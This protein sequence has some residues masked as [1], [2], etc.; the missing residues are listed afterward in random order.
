MLDSFLTSVFL[1]LMHLPTINHINLSSIWN[2]PLSSLALSVNLHQLDIFHMKCSNPLEE[3]DSI[4][5]V[6]QSEMPKIREFHTFG[7]ALLT[8][9]FLHAKKHDQLAFNL[10]DLRWL[11]ISYDTERNARY[12]LQNAKLL[13]KLHLTVDLGSILGLLSLRSSTLKVLDLKVPLYHGFACLSL[14]G[15]CEELEAMA[16]HNILEALSVEV[17]VQ[18]EDEMEDFIGSII[19]K[20]EKVLIKPGWSLLR[21]VSFKVSVVDYHSK[22]K[23]LCK[24]LQFLPDKYLSHL[25]KLESVAFNYSVYVPSRD[26]AKHEF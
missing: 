23:E 14:E 22:R 12:L 16:G 10:M 6:V 19:Q 11:S 17:R 9:K 13:E 15:L 25:P 4:K 20:V 7:S 24:V 8:T 3:D 1:H 2:F 21:Q 26:F 5:I 18:N